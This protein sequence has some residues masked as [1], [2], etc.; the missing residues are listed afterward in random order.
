MKVAYV[1]D[2]INH[3]KSLQTIGT[4]IVILL[5]LLESVESIDVYCPKE[6]KDTEEFEFPPKVR[7]LE[8][9]RY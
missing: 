8:S 1:G 6:N 4:S 7:L 3:G 5:S 9:C 2:F